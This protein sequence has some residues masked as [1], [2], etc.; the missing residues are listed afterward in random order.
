MRR[1]LF[2]LGLVGSLAAQGSIKF[3]FQNRYDTVLTRTD[4]LLVKL[5]VLE[6][7]RK[8]ARAGYA[9]Y[10]WHDPGI[11][12]R[13]GNVDSAA[14]RAVSD[15]D[16]ASVLRE[17]ARELA[18]IDDSGVLDR[19]RPTGI[20][21]LSDTLMQVKALVPFGGAGDEGNDSP[22]VSA[23]RGEVPE[24]YMLH[25]FGPERR[26][27]VFSTGEGDGLIVYRNY[28]DLPDEDLKGILGPPA[29]PI[30]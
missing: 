12:A 9:A 23:D 16:R 2:V 7:Q 15:T 27:W 21:F 14:I 29:T 1:A 30:R 18:V 17:I 10:F 13:Y 20:R 28:L 25:R 22:R 6:F 19:I 26:W 24:T 3:D 8:L 5:T 4:T 11:L